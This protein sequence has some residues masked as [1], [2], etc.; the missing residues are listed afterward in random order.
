LAVLR[1]TDLY[2]VTLDGEREIQLTHGSLGAGFAG[3]AQIDGASWIYYTSM[4]ERFPGPDNF[5]QDE[6][7]FVV[8]RRTLNGPLHELEL[9]RFRGNLK[10]I[11]WSETNASVSPDGRYVAYSDR[12]GIK[13]F[14]SSMSSHRLLAAHGVCTG[15]RTEDCYGLYD[16]TWSPTGDWIAIRMVFYEGGT[17]AFAR[18]DEQ[19]AVLIRSPDGR[20]GLFRQ[21]YPEQTRLCASA[22]GYGGGGFGVLD[23]PMQTFVDLSPIVQNAGEPI[24]VQHCDVNDSNELA[25]VTLRADDEPATLTLIGSDGQTV[26]SFN[27]DPYVGLCCWLPDASGVIVWASLP[28]T[29]DRQNLVVIRDGSFRSLPF[30]MGRIL[31]SWLE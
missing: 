18:P 13:L 30:D 24:L 4:V 22:S 10:N 20:G 26:A 9:F 29:R 19:Q 2:A 27:V 11:E 16:P 1:G 25:V 3:V 12:D 28:G 31:G 6:A 17:T 14:D 21:W 5:S 23:A 8:A 15:P 7:E